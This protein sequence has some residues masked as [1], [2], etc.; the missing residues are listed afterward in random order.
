[1]YIRILL[2]ILMFSYAC[3][4]GCSC[5]HGRVYICVLVCVRECVCVYVCVC[6]CVCA[7][8]CVCIDKGLLVLL[9][10]VVYYFSLF[11]MFMH[12]QR[13]FHRR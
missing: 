11:L 3:L 12:R 4:Y 10:S 7:C 9:T 2:L 13:R 6:V 1:M 8:M 5:V